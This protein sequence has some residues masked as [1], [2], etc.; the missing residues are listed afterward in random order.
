MTTTLYLN[1]NQAYSSCR[2][3]RGGVYHE[4]VARNVYGQLVMRVTCFIKQLKSNIFDCA[5]WHNDFHNK[6]GCCFV[7]CHKACCRKNCLRLQHL[8]LCG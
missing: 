3:V 5:H 2:R 4:Q 6:V 7:F 1:I 8:A